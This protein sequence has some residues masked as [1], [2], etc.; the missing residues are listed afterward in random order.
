MTGS[1]GLPTGN[2]NGEPKGSVWTGR[3]RVRGPLW[4]QLPLLTIGMLGL[5]I[6][7]SVEMAYG[8]WHSSFDNDQVPDLLS[9]SVAVL[10]VSWAEEIPYGTGIRC[11]SPIRT[12]HA[13]SYCTSSLGRR[14]PY[15]LAAS[16][17][18][19]G[20]LM[21]LGFT[22][23]FS[24]IFGG[25]SLQR[26]AVYAIFC[27]DFSIN[28][29]QAVDR[30]LLVDILPPALQAAGNAWAGR[31]FG[32]G[33]V[34]G[35]F[36]GGI[37]LPSV[38]P[39]LGRTQLE[40]LS[41]ISSVLLL[42]LHG[43]TAASVEEKVLVTDGALSNSCGF[44]VITKPSFQEFYVYTWFPS[45]WI[46]WFPVL[47]YSSTW[48]GDIY[49]ATAMENGRV[50]D[51]P[52]L[53]DDAT[54]IGSLAL[55]YS[56]IL[57]FA[58]S[59][60]APF[61]IRSNRGAGSDAPRGAMDKLK[62]SLGGL[63]SLSQ[64]IFACSMM[65]TL[66]P[67]TVTSA[68]IIITITGFCWAVSQ[69]LGEAILLSAPD[70]TAVPHL[71]HAEDEIPLTDRRSRRRS[72][73][74][75]PPRL[76]RSSSPT[77]PS[78]KSRS[79]TPSSTHSSS[80]SVRG[81]GSTPAS[82][83]FSNDTARRSR[84]KLEKR[85]SGGTR[86]G[87]DDDFQ[88]NNDGPVDNDALELEDGELEMGGDSGSTD[89]GV[90]SKAGIILGIHN[91]VVVLPQFLVTG[92]SA[93]LFALFEPHRSVLHGKHPGNVPPGTN[94]TLPLNN[95]EIR[96]EEKDQGDTKAIVQTPTAG[97]HAMA[98]TT[99]MN[100]TSVPSIETT[101][102]YLRTLPSIR[103][104]CSRVHDLAKEGKLEYFDYHPEKEKD[105]VEFC[106]KIIEREFGSAYDTI[107][108]HSRWR[109]FDAGHE[110]IAPLLAQWSKEL[111]PLETTKRL[112]DLFLVSVLL[113]AGA[114]NAWAY[115]E[116]G[117][118]K[119]GRSEGLAIASLDMF[120]AGF[121]SSDGGLKVDAAGLK[122]ITPEKTGE[123]MQ[124]SAS[125]PMSGLEGRSNLLA[126]LGGALSASPEIFGSDGRPGNLLGKRS[127]SF[128]A[129][130]CDSYTTYEKEFIEKQGKSKNGKTYVHMSAL[131]HVLIEGLAP[132][133][134][135][136]RTQLGGTSLGDVWPCSA[137]HASEVTPNIGYSKDTPG[138]DL[139]P[140]H[141][142]SQWLAYSLVEPI[143]KVLGWKIEG[144]EDMTGLPEY[145]NGGLL[146]DLGVLTLRKETVS[147]F[148]PNPEIDIARLAPSHPA[149]IEWRAMTVI[150]LDRIAEALREHLNAP[151]L[152]LAQVLES[153]TWKGGREIAK[154]KRPETAGPPIEI[155]SD[156]T[157]F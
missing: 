85:V 17:V 120:L 135:A 146:V 111:T 45:S 115:T 92:L 49:K 110:R 131:W 20:G 97:G 48:V 128:A 90:G 50:E 129:F 66:L 132:I 38:F 157:V 143:E 122:R 104:R 123:A 54:R 22:R 23:E 113:D 107:P 86:N 55:L 8:V 33:S 30:A 152:A 125:N 5:Q 37:N 150:E 147:S 77:N 100:I 140:F 83:L 109:H 72:S 46:A 94:I 62:I 117:G 133:W 47:F 21:L 34:A 99:R 43:I 84:P 130:W 98:E 119:F 51:D 12:H 93:V 27:I 149:I 151:N 141:K 32:L 126:N 19:I 31:M 127:Q 60:V 64:G 101:I 138:S 108:P 139:V 58:V 28:A 124:V 59:I 148:Y 89:E 41:V 137:L 154:Q 82:A 11:W 10:A 1:F 6:V 39:S 61:F 44:P 116:S 14:R 134:P 25:V 74:P 75:S 95:L 136:T 144:M 24:G 26:I 81:E 71:E 155:E 80:S 106:A 57:S 145:R 18:S 35:F 9:C 73:S 69:W 53:H 13:T 36:I 15:M 91:L 3:A 65:A 63:W 103:E 87:T 68:T 142:L 156:G 56:S 2:S 76:S 79:H 40:V 96:E 16:L 118:E 102:A 7:W 42:S 52:T 114:G 121:F 70:Y 78:R 29:V 153:A 67:Q 105:V 112:I 4:A 88:R